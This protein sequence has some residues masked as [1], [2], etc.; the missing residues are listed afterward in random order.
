MGYWEDRQAEI[1]DKL[2]R[3]KVKEVEKQLAKYYGAAAKQVIK[4]FEDTYNKLLAT[5]ADGKEP[6]PADLYKL[7]KY[8]QMQGQLRQALNKLGEKQIALLTKEFE[9]HFF[10]IYYSFA[11]PGVDAFNTIDAEGARRMINA[12][13]LADGKHFTQRIW[14]NT[15]RLVETLNDQL[16]HTVVAGKKTTEL[17]H[18]LMDRFNV[19]YSRADTLVRTEL[20]HVQTVAAKQRYEDYGIKKYRILGNDDDSCGNHG[21]DCHEMDGKEFLFAEMVQGKNAPP[22]HPNCKCSIVPVVE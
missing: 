18:L 8:W 11:L 10:D 6:T 20:A 12:I 2:T 9:L 14:G 19:S 1:Q 13:W 4:D 21:V 5:M 15:E 3:K 7:D 22:F 17:K 16:V